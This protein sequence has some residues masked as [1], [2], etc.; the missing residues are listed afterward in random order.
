[1]YHLGTPTRPPDANSRGGKAS[2]WIPGLNDTFGE[3]PSKHKA[4][5]CTFIYLLNGSKFPDGFIQPQN[6]FRPF[7]QVARL[8]IPVWCAPR[9]LCALIIV[10][11]IFSFRISC[12]SWQGSFS[13]AFTSRPAIPGHLNRFRLDL[14]AARRGN[15]PGPKRAVC[16]GLQCW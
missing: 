15:C 7:S 11:C 10:V 5:E 3:L 14:Q 9:A 4:R 12:P 2:K 6:P 1:M 13:V 16:C 8:R